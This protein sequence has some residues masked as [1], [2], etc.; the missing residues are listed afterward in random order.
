MKKCKPVTKRSTR[1]D[2]INP[3]KATHPRKTCTLKTKNIIP[4]GYIY[5]EING[6]GDCFWDAAFNCEDCIV[7]GGKNNPI[8]SYMKEQYLKLADTMRRA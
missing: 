3:C 4:C 1:A 7:N 5:D 2:C 6:D 8:K